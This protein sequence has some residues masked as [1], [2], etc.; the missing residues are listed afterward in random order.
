MVLNL[1]TYLR[2]TGDISNLAQFRFGKNNLKYAFLRMNSTLGDYLADSNY[3]VQ[4]LFIAG[5]AERYRRCILGSSA[6]CLF[7]AR[8]PESNAVYTSTVFLGRDCVPN[9]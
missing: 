6:V 5:P 4:R 1:R 2:S 9:L 3:L 7:E 8:A